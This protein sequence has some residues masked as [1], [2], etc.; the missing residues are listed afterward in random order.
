MIKK[1][2]ISVGKLS[3]LTH[4]SRATLFGER[5]FDSSKD[6]YLTLGVSK[7]S[8]ETDIKKAYYKLAKQYHPDQYKGNDG[9][10]K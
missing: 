7:D 1:G 6:Y 3:S 9:K 5:N 10:F 4:R 8:N 2:L